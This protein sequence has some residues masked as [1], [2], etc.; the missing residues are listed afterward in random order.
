MAETLEVAH[1]HVIRELKC[2]V[3]QL[4]EAC[5]I[6]ACA[7]ERLLD[8]LGFALI[9]ALHGPARDQAGA[10]AL[11]ISRRLKVGPYLHVRDAPHDLVMACGLA[12]AN[13]ATAA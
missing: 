11:R 2:G 5:D 9:G 10:H 3:T 1:R 12:V 7:D 13:L 4:A 6:D 8:L